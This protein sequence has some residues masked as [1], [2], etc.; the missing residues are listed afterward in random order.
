MYV[1][2][3]FKFRYQIPKIHWSLKEGSL[4]KIIKTI[5]VI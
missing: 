4:K 2:R 5:F 1:G 3:A